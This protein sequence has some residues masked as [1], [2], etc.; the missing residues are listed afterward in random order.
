[1][2][3]EAVE[4]AINAE[5]KTGLQSS[6][7]T[8]KIDSKCPRDYWPLIKKDKEQE[9]TLDDKTKSY[10]SLANIGQPQTLTEVFKK[11]NRHDSRQGY[12]AIRVNET[13]ISKKNKN[14]NK[15]KKDL[16]HIKCYTYKQ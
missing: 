15:N 7:E 14:K 12:L 8:R 1:M 16:S 9:I 6:P 2:L 11:N 5:V 13:E 4:K 10:N 3:E